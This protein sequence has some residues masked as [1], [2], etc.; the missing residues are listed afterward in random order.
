MKKHVIRLMSTAA[1]AAFLALPTAAFAAEEQAQQETEPAPAKPSHV[2]VETEGSFTS[3]Q[4]AN[5]VYVFHE[6]GPLF[7]TSGK[8]QTGSLKDLFVLPYGPMQVPFV[9]VKNADNELK[10][11]SD[12]WPEFT[13]DDEKK[14][15][16]MVEAYDSGRVFYT[17]QDKIVSKTGHHYAE[18]DG[19]EVVAYTANDFKDLEKGYHESIRVEGKL[20]GL[21]L[22]DCCPFA[23]V[24]TDKGELLVYHAGEKGAET[25]GSIDL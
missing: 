14:A 25:A 23:V 16:D 18:Q 19:K 11:F 7:Q 9:L 4:I 13:K 22:Y 17:A 12:L 15:N 1:L 20:R 24:E 5:T 6:D 21:I 2:K 10:V 8:G 3:L